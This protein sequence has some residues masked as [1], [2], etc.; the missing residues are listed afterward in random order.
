MQLLQSSMV[1]ATIKKNTTAGFGWERFN[2]DGYG[3]N[4]V[5]GAPWTPTHGG[6]GHVWAVLAAERDEYELARGNRT[7]TLAILNTLQQMSFG[8]GLL[9]EQNWETNRVARSPFGTDPLIASI[10]FE[11]GRAAGS[12]TP[13]M[14]SAAAYVRLFRNTL[15]GEL[16]EQPK[17]NRTRCMRQEFASK[18]IGSR[19]RRPK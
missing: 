11:N 17:L 14:W 10:G 8:V 15:A 5:S 18:K 13:L 16:L 7:N 4:S 6:N 19:C 3:D 9:P 1:D 12:A 2:G